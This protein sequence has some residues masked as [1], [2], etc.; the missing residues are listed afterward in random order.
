MLL[1]GNGACT[2]EGCQIS[3]QLTQGHGRN[4]L[5]EL[6]QTVYSEVIA[7]CS[8]IQ[9]AA[10]A[11]RSAVGHCI[12]CHVNQLNGHVAC[13]GGG[14]GGGGCLQLVEEQLSS[15]RQNL[16]TT[17]TKLSLS[18]HSLGLSVRQSVRSTERRS[19]SA[20]FQMP[21]D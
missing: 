1:C 21:T 8:P 9:L 2:R 5:N 7:Y 14:G 4:S 10:V 20:G 16:P 13:S 18:T 6:S 19:L 15:S 3:L 11:F 12:D 17:L